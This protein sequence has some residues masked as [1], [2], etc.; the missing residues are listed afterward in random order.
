MAKHTPGPWKLHP[1]YP[2]QV[3]D[4]HA[5]APN[6]RYNLNNLICDCA[7]LGDPDKSKAQIANARLIAAAPELLQACKMALSL[8]GTDAESANGCPRPEEL[9]IDLRAVIAKAEGA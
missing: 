1:D 3:F 7:T 2:N 4:S 5:D 6:V 9:A 8:I